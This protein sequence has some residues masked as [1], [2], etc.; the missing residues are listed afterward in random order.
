MKHKLFVAENVKTPSRKSFLFDLAF[1]FER[2]PAG[3]KAPNFPLSFHSR[4]DICHLNALIS[5]CKHQEL[6]LGPF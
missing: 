1:A 3:V 5:D 4:N 6:P 2:C